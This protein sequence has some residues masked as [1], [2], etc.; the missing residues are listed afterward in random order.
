MD[1]LQQGALLPAAFKNLH[2]DFAYGQHFSYASPRV[3]LAFTPALQKI[4]ADSM[5]TLGFGFFPDQDGKVVWDVAQVWLAQD[6]QDHHWLSLRRI[7]APP[8]DLDDSYQARWKKV[9]NRQH[10][11]DAMAY[12]ENDTTKIDTVV[13][14]P[15]GGAAKV[16]Y[17]AYVYQPGTQPQAEMKA[18]LELL[19]KGVKVMEQ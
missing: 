17:T 16:L 9:L 4:S 10:P 8:A 5:L 6:S 12:S 14:P 2:I 19:L 18:K 7:D 13:P 3:A 1:F 15:R 11:F